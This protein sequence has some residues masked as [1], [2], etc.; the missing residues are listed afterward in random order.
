MKLI[1]LFKRQVLLAVAIMGLSI[2]EA[3]VNR[4]PVPD[5]AYP[6]T[7]SQNAR[8]QMT[9][10][11][12]QGDEIGA[13][14]ALT[15]F[16]LAESNIGSENLPE[17]ISEIKTAQKQFSGK[18]PLA[19]TNLLLAEIYTS[20]FNADSY[21]YNS[22]SLPLTPLPEHYNEWSGDQFR[23]EISR[24]CA[25][26][27]ANAS[28]LQRTPIEDYSQLVDVSRSS[29]VYFPTMYD[30]VAHRSISLLNQL[31]RFSYCLGLVALTPRATFILA[32]PRTTSSP[33]TQ[34]IMDLYADLLR[35]HSSNPAPEIYCDIQRINF[36]KSHAYSNLRDDANG[37][38][39]TLLKGLYYDYVTSE[40]SG[41]ALIALGDYVTLTGSTK[42]ISAKEYY[43]MLNDFASRHRTFA[44]I[45]CIESEIQRL[46][47]PGV[48]VEMPSNIA[49]GHPFDA[50]VTVNNMNAVTLN[51]YRINKPGKRSEN[52][53]TAQIRNSELKSHKPERSIVV[54]FDEQIP[55]TATKTI[56]LTVPDFGI[57]YL[58]PSECADN[59]RNGYSSGSRATRLAIGQS[60]DS[61]SHNVFVIDPLTGRP[62]DKA[63]VLFSKDSSEPK[64]IGTTDRD[65]F[66]KLPDFNWGSVRPVMASDIFSA[67]MYLST[68]NDYVA[69]WSYHTNAY[70]DLPIYHPGDTVKWCAVAYCYRNTDRK[71]LHDT[72]MK[73]IMFNANSIAV[74][75]AEVTTDI[76]GR[77]NGAFAIPKGELTGPYRIVFRTDKS[78]AGAVTFT[79]SD[80]KMPTY[81]IT[82]STP[83]SGT[84]SEGDV[85][86][87]G[88]VR[89]YSGVNMGGVPVKALISVSTGGWWFRSNSIDFCSL[90]DTT[91]ADGSFNLVLSK[92]QIANSPAP[93]G[94]FTAKVSATSLSGESQQASTDFTVGNAYV[95]ISTLPSA[96]ETS[97]TIDMARHFA[98]RDSKGNVIDSPLGFTLTDNRSGSDTITGILGQEMDLH[99]LS[100]STYTLKVYSTQ[101]HPDTLKT[102][103]ILYGAK[104]SASPVDVPVWSPDS[105]L[106]VQPGKKAK[107]NLFASQ[108]DVMA[109]M[110]TFDYRTIYQSRW[111]RL[112]KGHNEVEVTIPDGKKSIDVNVTSTLDYK[113]A[114]LNFNVTVANS[115]PQLSIITET[116]RNQLIPGQRETWTFR[117]V[118]KD[119]T[120]VESALILN[121]Y[122]AALNSL[123]KSSKE[124][125]F[126]DASPD[127]TNVSLFGYTGSTRNGYRPSKASFDC[128]AIN[129]PQLQTYGLSFH[130]LMRSRATM[131][132]KS[133][134]VTNRSF[135]HVAGISSDLAI[136]E[137]SKEEA[138]E[139]MAESAVEIADAGA[140]P[141][142]GAADTETSDRSF[143]YRQNETP[144][145]FFNPTLT[146]DAA[147]HL[148]FS[149]DLPDANTTW[150]F[151]A[152]AYD[153]DLSTSVL[154]HKIVANKP[155]MV[156][157]NLPRFLRAADSATVAA[158]VM[159]NSDQPMDITVNVELFNPA[160]MALISRFPSEALT[161]A[162]NSSAVT[163]VNITAP[164]QSPFIGYRIK[165][166]T[167]QYADGEQTLIP[168]LPA[169]EQ[170]IE[171]LPFYISPDSSHFAMRLP[172]YSDNA[173]V[174]LQ[175]CDNP[176]WYVVTALPGLTDSEPRTAPEA[177]SAIFSGAVASGL[178]RSVPQIA[179][180]LRQWTQSDGSDSTLTS[181]LQRNADLKTFLLQAT[182]WMLDARSDTERMQRLALLFDADRLNQ[183]LNSAITLLDKLQ[184][185]GGGWAW[186]NQYT[187]PSMW[188][189]YRTLLTLGRLNTLGF[190]PND[191]RLNKMINAA[192]SYYQAETVKAYRKRPSSD[193]LDFALLLDCYP[194]FK[195][196]ST[197]QSIIARVVQK[198]V[199]S[200]R[201]YSLAGKA[202]AA[203]L[204]NS[205]GYKRVS[206]Q[207]LESL[208]QYAKS[209]PTQGMYWPLA[210]DAAGGTMSELTLTARILQTFHTVSPTAPE[211]D[212]IRQWLILQ[213]EARDW[214]KGDAATEVCASV[215]LTSPRWITPASPATISIGAD[216]L[217]ISPTDATLGYLRTDITS[218]Q[219]AGKELSIQKT[220]L[221]P[222]W[223]A[224]YSR[225]IQPSAS[226]AA[227]SIPTLDITK[228]LYELQ[229]DKWVS[230]APGTT[231]AV[232]TKVKVE[233][234]IHS[235]RAMDYVAIRDNRSACLEPVEQLP[236]PVFSEGLCFYRE[237]LDSSTAIFISNLPAGTYRLSYEMW[238]NNAGTYTTGI[239]TIQS[240]YAP[241][242]TAHS[243]GSTMTVTPLP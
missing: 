4:T 15:D 12:K 181:M 109:L 70:T 98:L 18:V 9:S 200:W 194:K 28:E 94:L 77:I 68:N 172:D 229:G 41:D 211:I 79:V 46:K 126:F 206:L 161:V 237:N 225:S 143:T 197:A 97:H 105:K 156:Q 144:L 242:L 49:P 239:A 50:K 183:S 25:E 54:N 146:T 123:V 107:I 5:F 91:A 133:A 92:E 85:T 119:S 100:P 29:R 22:R 158:T 99:K 38:A 74:D 226:I 93:T 221:T 87:S 190:L 67:Q 162:P 160:T 231:L 96:I 157:P 31:D 23:N 145:S 203:L 76:W 65:G 131:M 130:P 19:V 122:N 201:T 59:I 44:R 72:P 129:I 113:T 151:T 214:G 60:S 112:K 235:T 134:A 182:P 78:S 69:D 220:D 73:A 20:A 243:A 103:V 30:F 13:L 241:A 120:G 234:L 39:A 37:S 199:K 180:A 209:S 175:F 136:V 124:M 32:P 138:A 224:V 152:L 26:A 215:L 198:A 95:I 210:A 35:F 173:T 128:L 47:S 238:V 33:F 154:R 159:N 21:V 2:A 177:A 36:S 56:S 170:V 48:F 16:A 58:V 82:L 166:S 148:T 62:V 6:Q 3:A 179:T 189:T 216:S 1:T 139:D 213:K 110:S 230:V 227:A 142:A 125:H 150:D 40:Y 165:A 174:T 115:T 186:I 228:Q 101:Y 236:T 84:P 207:I 155:L 196:S 108:D 63:A 86:I 240:Q 132:Y 111:L 202:S 171:A 45:G 127:F 17:V 42:Y 52:E 118:D 164:S 176:T 88:T 104:A 149:F 212:R 114:R 223:G 217:A 153:R 27:L 178:L 89:T 64:S 140:T 195:P 83:A 222:A 81:Y 169:S 208:R 137:E 121:M 168:I 106:S 51:L 135:V 90:S 147:G 11:L 205:H 55:F 193:Y 233:L 7:V 116:F 117:T 34:Q 80:Y 75:T 24:L 8:K 185:K 218:T 14:R 204:L 191:S 71:L 10:M 141:G 66:L 61:V 163:S 192:L 188:A 184:R 57:Y 43:K 102:S 167:D 219:P 187:E 232:G 53:V